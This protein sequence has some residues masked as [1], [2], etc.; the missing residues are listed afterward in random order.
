MNAAAVTHFHAVCHATKVLHKAG[1][2]VSQ[3]LSQLVQAI[4]ALDDDLSPD[5]VFTAARALLRA[6]NG[7]A[8]EESLQV[9][10]GL[11]R[12]VEHNWPEDVR[13]N[14]VAAVAAHWNAA[15]NRNLF[16]KKEVCSLLQRPE[17]TLHWHVYRLLLK[18]VLHGVPVCHAVDLNSVY[19][20]MDLFQHDSALQSLACRLLSLHPD[21]SLM[22]TVPRVCRAMY[23]NAACLKVQYRGCQALLRVLRVNNYRMLTRPGVQAVTCCITYARTVYHHCNLVVKTADQIL[24]LLVESSTLDKE[25]TKASTVSLCVSA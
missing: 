2:L 3:H 21:I 4:H 14:A 24:G 19:A 11:L 6:G 1:L 18:A 12:R 7:L 13:L 23:F 25:T 8:T 17:Q 22:H 9:A 16:L 20:S 5:E 10:V 15:T